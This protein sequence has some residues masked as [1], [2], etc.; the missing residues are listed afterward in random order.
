MFISR[1]SAELC[2]LREQDDFELSNCGGEIFQTV[3]GLRRARFGLLAIKDKF[4]MKL[5]WDI[6]GV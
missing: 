4:T 3:V 2:H 1:V 6:I 5:S